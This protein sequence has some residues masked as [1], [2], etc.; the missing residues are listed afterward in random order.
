MAGLRFTLTNDLHL[1][2]GHLWNES[3]PGF[4][5]R[6]ERERSL[7]LVLAGDR[8]T[9]TPTRYAEEMAA[10]IPRAELKVFPGTHVIPIERK[11]QVAE[12]VERFVR[13]LQP[14][15][16]DRTVEE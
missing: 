5:A 13:G 4:L 2:L 7:R 8:D 6:L 14:D 9:F 10:L 12:I 11:D 3:L 1:D 15:R 16:Q